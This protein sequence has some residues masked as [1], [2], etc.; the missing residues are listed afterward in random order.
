MEAITEPL[1]FKIPDGSELMSGQEALRI[2]WR[3]NVT[4]DLRRGVATASLHLKRASL[5]SE[6]ILLCNRHRTRIQRGPV[7]IF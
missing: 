4:R 5:V 3:G 2:V 1:A 7:T 6:W